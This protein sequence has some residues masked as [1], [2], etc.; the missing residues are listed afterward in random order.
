[1]KKKLLS[2]L[3]C[4]V[5]V[6]GLLPTVAFAGRYRKGNPAWHKRDQRP[7]RN[8]DQWRGKAGG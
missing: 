2:I 5:M 4:L 8:N 3:L 7:D 6:V 1:M